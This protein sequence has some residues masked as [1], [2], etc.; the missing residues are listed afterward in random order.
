[1]SRSTS[2][3]TTLVAASPAELPPAAAEARPERA[4]T[5]ALWQRD[6]ML[7][8]LLT[9]LVAMAWQISERAWV[10]PQDTL[11]YWVG[12]A[13]A[14]MLLLLFIYPLR[15]Y[16]GWM[17][18]IG[19]VKGWFWFH[20][21]MGVTGPW[22]IL[23]HSGF[24]VGSTNAAVALYSM[25]VVVASGVIGRFLYVRLNSH[26]E[27]AEERLQR[28]RRRAGLSEA[29]TLAPASATA[30][31]APTAPSSPSAL[32]YAPAVEAR[33]TVFEARELGGEPTPS[34]ALRQVLLL[35]LQSRLVLGRC[36][37]ELRAPLAARAE[38]G[39]WS[40]DEVARRRR[41]AERL[42]DDWIDAVVRV[43]RQQAFGRVFAL[44]HLAHLPFIYLLVIST[45]V[46]VVAVHAY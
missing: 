17:R 33:L 5:G 42:V 10:R 16:A 12:V 4:P 28:V 45:V 20:L 7:M 40:S 31:T 27:D 37:K 46:H 39:R 22:L 29:T 43:A 14:S 11:G 1:M 34:R 21:S 30:A 32:H 24:H 23:V 25:A 19:T 8:L 44:W 3:D 18:R 38:A 6:L 26:I 15:K 13:G 9:A 2:A 41:R 35:P 36:L